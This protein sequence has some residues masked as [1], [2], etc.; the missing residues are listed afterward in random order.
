Q[1]ALFPDD[2][3]RADEDVALDGSYD[4]RVIA[5]TVKI[6]ADDLVP[7][8]RAR[9]RKI[10]R[11]L[12][13]QALGKSRG[14]D[15]G[16]M[17]S[18]ELQDCIDRAA[19]RFCPGANLPLQLYWNASRGLYTYYSALELGARGKKGY[20]SFDALGSIGEGVALF[21]LEDDRFGLDL[22]YRPLSDS[23]DL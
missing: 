23:P 6:T 5:S 19:E 16:K 18:E 22:L 10:A 17:L 20:L 21:V 11:R 9:R 1:G 2:Q 4:V 13:E 14:I 8:N 3:N 7:W 12:V 15:M